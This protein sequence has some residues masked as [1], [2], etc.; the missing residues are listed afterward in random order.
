MAAAAAKP[1]SADDTGVAHTA[2]GAPTPAPLASVVETDAID[3]PV[4]FDRLGTA[5]EERSLTYEPPVTD[6]E[7]AA[8]AGGFPEGGS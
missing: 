2:E 6:G 4:A 5:G 3:G 7:D 1:R 8:R